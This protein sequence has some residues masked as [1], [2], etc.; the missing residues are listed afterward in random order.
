[1]KQQAQLLGKKTAETCPN[2]TVSADVRKSDGNLMATFRRE[3]SLLDER[4]EA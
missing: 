4:S 2:M 3:S 1:M